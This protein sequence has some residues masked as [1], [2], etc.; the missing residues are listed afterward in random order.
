LV[1]PDPWRERLRDALERCDVNALAALAD[2]EDVRTRRTFA[3]PALV[4]KLE[5]D[6]RDKATVKLLRHAQWE[7]PE[8]FWLA[9][10]ERYVQSDNNHTDQIVKAVRCYS[11]A[12][13][14]R[15]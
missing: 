15:T 7:H 1:D 13:V 5:A 11:I 9:L 12:V 2:G 4:V 8:D 6:G 14:T 10:Y 3:L